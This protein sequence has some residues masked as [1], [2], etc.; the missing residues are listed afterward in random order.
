[1]KGR[2]TALLRKITSA[3]KRHPLVGMRPYQYAPTLSCDTGIDHSDVQPHHIPI[4][5]C[6]GKCDGILYDLHSNGMRVWIGMWSLLIAES[7]DFDLAARHIVAHA[8][9]EMAHD[10]HRW[11][12]DNPHAPWTRYGE[13]E[14]EGQRIAREQNWWWGEEAQ[15]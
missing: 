6:I 8:L 15:P 4:V 10:I 7:D 11:L 5:V 2:E 14:V 1:M 12:A 13:R 9:R 3:I